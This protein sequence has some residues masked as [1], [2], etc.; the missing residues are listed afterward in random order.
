MSSSQNEVDNTSEVLQTKDKID[1]VS[2]LDIEPIV[3]TD[4]NEVMYSTLL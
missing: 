3:E 2:V 1:S 4:G